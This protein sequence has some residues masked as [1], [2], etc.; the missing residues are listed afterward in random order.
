MIKATDSVLRNDEFIT[1]NYRKSLLSTVY[2]KIKNGR[3]VLK[4]K[5][6][7]DK[8]NAELETENQEFKSDKVYSKS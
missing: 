4:L 1:T 8:T 3:D 5:M 6:E 2:S 7:K